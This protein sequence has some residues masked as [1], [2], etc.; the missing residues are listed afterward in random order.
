MKNKLFKKSISLIMSIV[1]VVGCFITTSMPVL[2]I[3]KTNTPA[4][5][6]KWYNADSQNKNG[7][8]KGT[9]KRIEKCVPNVT[10]LG[11]AFVHGGNGVVDKSYGIGKAVP[12]KCYVDNED[13]RDSVTIQGNKIDKGWIVRGNIQHLY[14]LHHTPSIVGTINYAV[15]D[16]SIGWPDD[17]YYD[18]FFAYEGEKFQ[19]VDY[20]DEWVYFWSNGTKSFDGA[21]TGYCKN[22][23]LLRSHPAGFYRMAKKDVWINLYKNDEYVKTTDKFVGKGYVSVKANLYQKPSVT[24]AGPCYQVA[25]NTCLQ[26]SSLTPVKSMVEGDDKTYYK[27]EFIGK[28]D[29]YYMGYKYYY[30]Y[31]ESKYINVYE[32]INKNNDIKLP[33]KHSKAYIYKPSVTVSSELIYTE[34]STS[35]EKFY[36][37]LGDGAKVYVDLSKTDDDWVAVQFNDKIGYVESKR[38]KYY[39][40]D[41][42]VED[43]KDN[44]YVI[45]WT[46]TPTE[47]KLVYKDANGNLIGSGKIPKG[48]VGYVVNNS[49]FEGREGYLGG[50]KVTLSAAG[51]DKYSGSVFLRVPEKPVFSLL[52]RSV[53]NNKFTVYGMTEG[54]QLQYSTNKNFK[55]V[56][57]VVAKGNTVTLKKLKKNTKYY[58]RYRNTLKV[59]TKNGKK[60]IYSEW[61]KTATIKTTNIKV[62]TP[63]LLTPVSLGDK[64][65]LNWK[66][67]NG[68]ADRHEIVIATDKKFTKNVKKTVAMKSMCTIEI[69]ELKRNKTYYVRMRSVYNHSGQVYYSKWTKV[70]T[71]KSK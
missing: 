62:K 25:T 60:T 61:S 63:T 46:K 24:D 55:N 35:S 26:V 3:S 18:E 70:K 68:T 5:S 39:I 66:K 38:I 7:P 9:N 30:A 67:Y 16:P 27:V 19:V 13:D 31:V 36:G 1:F 41:V 42:W 56:K 49:K 28:N 2:A 64:V 6:L 22:W 51:D 40:D 15:S 71:F 45:K 4:P 33:E 32:Y 54:S 20:D 29:T 21:T 11:E 65:K 69:H 8:G 43:V 50:L 23:L 58:L 57:S 53:S 17:A 37:A 52:A 47:V 12:V 48:Y 10:V 44:K 34:K 59:E 14:N